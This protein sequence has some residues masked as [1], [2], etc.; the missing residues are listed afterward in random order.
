MIDNHDVSGAS[1]TQSNLNQP[2][3]RNSPSTPTQSITITNQPEGQDVNNFSSSLNQPCKQYKPPSWRARL[4]L[5]ELPKL[6]TQVS[7]SIGAEKPT[8]SSNSQ[9][10]QSW[11][12][13]T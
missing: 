12:F 3:P 1:L 8:C 10:Q 13:F 4:P 2:H 7:R 9:K 11:L 6:A 5:I